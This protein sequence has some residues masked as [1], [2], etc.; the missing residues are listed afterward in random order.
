MQLSTGTAIAPT[1]VITIDNRPV[2]SLRS[3]I[4]GALD[5]ADVD[6]DVHGIVLTGIF[7]RS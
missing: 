4:V 5:A 6:P 3:R 1:A 2:N 7:R